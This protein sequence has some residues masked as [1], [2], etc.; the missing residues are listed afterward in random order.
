[1]F[2]ISK[3]L[4]SIVFRRKEAPAREYGDV[5]SKFAK[6][7]PGYDTH[8]CFWSRRRRVLPQHTAVTLLFYKR[9]VTPQD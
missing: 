1:M 8:I 6:V 5:A 3:Y 4:L 2:V 9:R 7:F